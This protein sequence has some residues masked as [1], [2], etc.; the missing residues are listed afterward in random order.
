MPTNALNIW[1]QSWAEF[2]WRSLIEAA[3]ILIAVS[4]L[5]LIIHR[6]A[7]AQLGYGLFLLVLLKLLVPIEFTVPEWLA[8]LSPS[9]SAGR[10]VMWVARELPFQARARLPDAAPT[11]VERSPA[12]GITAEPRNPDVS[13]EA[14]GSAPSKALSLPAKLMLA[15]AAAVF[16]L[17]IWF[18]FVQIR[19]R[20]YF[21]GSIPLDPESLPVDFYQ[22]KRL[23][24]VRK[25]VFLM[26]NP[27][28][29]LPAAW[30]IMRSRLVVPNDM[31]SSFS[32][33][34]IKWILLHEL[35]HIRRSDLGVSLLQRIVQIIFFF[36][37]AVWIANWVIDQLREYA[38]DDLALATCNAPRSDCGK[39]FLSVIQRVRSL[40]TVMTAP[41]GVLNYNTVVKRRMVRILDTERKLHMGLS[42]GAAAFLLLA[43]VIFL[44][45]LQPDESLLA[46]Q[47]AGGQTGAG[48][49]FKKVEIPSKL[50]GGSQL[51][52]DGSRLAYASNGSLWIMPVSG[53]VA[54]KF[55]E[56]PSNWIQLEWKSCR[57]VSPGLRTASGLPLTA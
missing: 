39:G 31:G 40:P 12:A 35:A 49:K 25:P 45:T 51:S 54:A 44:P 32:P 26:S 33:N 24:G 11:A 48:P 46:Q 52:P 56:F 36:N 5:W 30:G 57:T 37:P 41:L 17:L 23:A 8:I 43:A 21:R 7:S 9:H 29:P 27:K 1:A 4:I 47:S 19:M 22:L 28:I 2:M 55:Q 10:T 42:A 34:E 15:W 14:T 13:N 53:K 3:V 6:K 38:S 50:P 18:F 20:Q 16:V